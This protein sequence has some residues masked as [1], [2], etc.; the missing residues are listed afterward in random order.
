MAHDLGLALMTGVDI[1]IPECR[2][3]V[4]QPTLKEISLIGEET[5]LTASQL[6]CITKNM[7][8]QGETLLSDT[9]NFQ[10]FMTIMQEKTAADKKKAVQ[11]LF[12]LIFPQYSI[13][14]TPNGL[15]ALKGE[16]SIIID[17]TNF[18]ALQ[19]VLRYIFCMDSN[20]VNN[21]T[22]NPGNQKAKEIAEKLMKARQRVAEQKGEANNSI[23]VRY[24]SILTIGIPSM[25]LED[26]LNLT[27]F[28]LFDLVER[29]MLYVN[30]DLDIKAR[31]AGG[32]PD[33]PVENW[34]K[35]LH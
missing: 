30:W 3:T 27:M 8:S 5:F 9:N 22:F 18:E 20:Q 28:Q 12:T 34:M 10:I 15:T 11:L 16:E 35:D 7:I 33:K 31:L 14:F 32:K 19:Y 2:I 4:H 6:L 17:E 29:Y 24:L 13:I 25:S 21:S 23:F 1:P 26:C